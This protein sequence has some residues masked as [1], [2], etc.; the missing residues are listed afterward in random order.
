MGIL[1]IPPARPALSR[2]PHQQDLPHRPMQ[3]AEPSDYREQDRHL[4]AG[5]GGA[6]G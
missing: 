5:C 1:V 6:S 2:G 3:M 4:L